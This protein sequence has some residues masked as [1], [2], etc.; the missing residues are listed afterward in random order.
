MMV[1][2]M[3]CAFFGFTSMMLECT[4]YAAHGGMESY[5]GCDAEPAEIVIVSPSDLECK[6]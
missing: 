2:V 4:D 1:R 3:A 6:P 5:F